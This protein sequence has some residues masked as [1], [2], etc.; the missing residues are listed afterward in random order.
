MRVARTET[1]M[2]YRTADN[3]RMQQLDFVLGQEIKT[4]NNHGAKDADICDILAGKYPKDFEWT[5]WHPQCRCYMTA[6]LADWSEIAKMEDAIDQG[7]TYT[8]DGVV[9]EPPDNFN[10]WKKDN[11]DKIARAE[12]RGTLP[13]FLRDNKSKMRNAAKFGVQ[14]AKLGRNEEKVARKVLADFKD[15]HN[16]TPEQIAN[17]KEVERVLSTKQGKPMVFNDADNGRG[18]TSNDKNNCAKCVM[19]HELRLRGFNVTATAGELETIS[20]NTRSGW[21]TIKGKTPEFTSQISSLNKDFYGRLDKC[22]AS[23]GSRYT[24][25]WTYNEKDGH[26]ISAVRTK[27]GLILYDPQGDSF[28]S[29]E[30]IRE[31]M[32]EDTKLEVLRVDRLKINTELLCSIVSLF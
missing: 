20:T 31:L 5:G 9:T 11:A 22:T 32:Q 1:N 8:P 12:E 25:G 16:Y 17:H 13:Y 21:L 15:I 7:K 29:K 23:I 27:K 4:S 2:A 26:I 24:I 6:I 30:E 19:A 18:N 10:Q 28:Y 14:G 3:E